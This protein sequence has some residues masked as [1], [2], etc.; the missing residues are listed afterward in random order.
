MTDKV[1][2]RIFP[3]FWFLIW[4]WYL[5]VEQDVGGIEHS[6]KASMK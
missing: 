2:V 5:L 6:Y 3:K 1:A 4:S